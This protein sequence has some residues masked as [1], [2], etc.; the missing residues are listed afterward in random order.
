[1]DAFMVNKRPLILDA[2]IQMKVRAADK[3]AFVASARRLG[4]TLTAYL[5][6]LAREAERA[7]PRKLASR[8]TDPRP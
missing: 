3:A 2:T 5:V 4:M 6:G 8:A 1:M 7:S